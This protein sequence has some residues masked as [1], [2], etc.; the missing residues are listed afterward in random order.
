MPAPRKTSPSP[1][2]VTDD[3]S[4]ATG[5]R[6]YVMAR[7]GASRAAAQSAIV[8]LD[9]AMNLFVDP[10]DDRKGKERRELIDTALEALGASSRALEAAEEELDAIDPEEGEPWDDDVD[11]DDEDEDEDS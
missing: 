10:E 4:D 8:A 6:D 7:I 11:E 2:L 1:R 9:E 5:A 3:D